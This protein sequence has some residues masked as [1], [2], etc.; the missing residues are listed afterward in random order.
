MEDVF[1]VS[2]EC[3]KLRRQCSQQSEWK[4]RKAYVLKGISTS[5]N[6]LVILLGLLVGV[7]GVAAHPASG[8]ASTA[9]LDTITALGFVISGI[10]A[11]MAA[12]GLERRAVRNKEMSIKLGRMVRSLNSL[13]RLG[14]VEAKRRRL[15]MI[16]EEFEQLELETFTEQGEVSGSYHSVAGGAAVPALV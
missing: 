13:Q 3:D 16:T 7:L 1:V 6:I 11:A 10:K 12:S 4:K 2:R 9:Y 8:A 15:E 5:A 14:D